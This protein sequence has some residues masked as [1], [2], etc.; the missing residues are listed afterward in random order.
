[1]SPR[2]S[3]AYEL[4]YG[5]A[6]TEESLGKGVQFH[7]AYRLESRVFV[8]DTAS[9]GADVALFTILRQTGPRTERGEAPSPV[10]VRLELAKVDAQGRVTADP[11]VSLA[12]PV[13]GPPSIEC[14]AFVECPRGTVMANRNWAA[15]EEGRTPRTWRLAGSEIINGARCAKLVGVQQSEDWDR[16]RGDRTAWRRQDTV[17]V[18]PTYGVAYRVERVIERREPGRNEPTHKSALTYELQSMLPYPQQLFEDRRRE[19]LQA[20]AFQESAAPLLPNPAKHAPQLQALLTR[21]D[22][23]LSQPPTPYR[24]AVLQ[25][26]RRLEAA[27]RGELPPSPASEETLHTAPSVATLGKPAP[28]FVVTDFMSQESARLRRWAGRPVLLVFYNP[29]SETLTELLTFAQTLHDTYKAQDLT[30]LGLAVTE[31]AERVRKQRADMKLNFPTLAGSGLRLTYGVE[32]T[33][34]LVLLDSAG[35]V[36]GM[37]TGWGRETPTAVTE[38]LKRSLAVTPPKQ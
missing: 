9:K 34:K 14:G 33:P 15:A 16:P 8:L 30:V 6:F 38:E 7:R 11:G 12:V 36:R 32:A 3:R 26:K 20:R 5:G 17:W 25:V 1:M 37:Y 19:I 24:E 29:T 27:R 23:H 18:A 28:D 21:I 31:D 22:Y 2:L 35:V 10:S 13:E 4:V